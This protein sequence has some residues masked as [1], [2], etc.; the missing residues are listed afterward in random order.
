MY[1]ICFSSLLLLMLSLFVQVS[2]LPQ[3][4]T[5]AALIATV[6]GE[7]VKYANVKVDIE[8]A[9]ARFRRANDR[10]PLSDADYR[11]VERDRCD[12]ELERLK[13]YIR[14]VIRRQQLARFGIQPTKEEIEERWLR[15][16]REREVEGEPVDL[17]VLRRQGKENLR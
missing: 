10:D 8:A 3:A 15:Y 2:A 14:G 9:R 17:E 5:D 16:V 13:T 7:A 11:A 6:N 12:Y 1:T 4:S